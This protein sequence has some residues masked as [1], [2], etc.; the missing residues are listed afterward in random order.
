MAI[1]GKNGFIRKQEVV[2]AKKLLVWRYEKSGMALPNEEAISAQAEKIV[3]DA[4]LN[5]D[6]EE[7]LQRIVN[8]MGV[9]C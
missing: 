6:G 5:A 8:E 4:I 7:F 3:D 1:F 9:V 2:F